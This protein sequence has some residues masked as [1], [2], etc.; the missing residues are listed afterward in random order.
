MIK[1]SIF[2]V[3]RT[4]TRAPTYSAF[5]LFAARRT[6]PWRLGLIPLIAPWALAYAFR[7]IPRRRL[8]EVMH[9]R[10]LGRRIARDSAERLAGLF[11]ED[12]FRSKLYGEGSAQI[13]A[14]RAENCRIILAT[15]APA[16]YIE[17]LAA[18]LSINDVVA[19][20]ST[21]LHDRLTDRIAGENCYGS[22][23]QRM[24]DDYL[25]RQGIAR[26]DV[27]IRFY[28]DHVSDLPTFEW[29]D[30]PIAVNPSRRLRE[31]A[32][33]RGWRIMDWQAN[34]KARPDRST[35]AEQH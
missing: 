25:A 35:V 33:L 29:A 12:I 5:L 9:N 18:Q 19:T 4:L 34:T 16:L 20:R 32:T 7:M 15:A 27:H 8:K 10:M 13:L 28:S 11:A 3:D 23:K 22:A 31:I 24:L 26:S 30:E 14:D 6:A 21:W 17:P 1:I 2:D